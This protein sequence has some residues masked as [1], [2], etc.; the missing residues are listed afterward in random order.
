MIDTN[1]NN[2]A[3][4]IKESAK[5]LGVFMIEIYQEAGIS[6]TNHRKWVGGVSPNVRTVLKIQD[7]VERIKKK[8][9]PEKNS[10]PIRKS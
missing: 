7:A 1:H 8:K 10:V 3:L 5:K 2:L 6:N 9:S 4:Y